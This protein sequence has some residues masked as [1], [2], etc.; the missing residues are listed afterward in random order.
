MLQQLH[1]FH[2]F[3]FDLF[4]LDVPSRPFSQKTVKPYRAAVLSTSQAEADLE[5]WQLVKAGRAGTWEFPYK[6]KPALACLH[7]CPPPSLKNSSPP[8]LFLERQ[9]RK[10]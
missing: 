1:R 6:A 8:T 5:G 2:S 4:S 9:L 10:G 3:F 7:A